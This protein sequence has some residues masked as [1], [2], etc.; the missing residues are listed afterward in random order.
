MDKV[1]PERTNEYGI[2]NLKDL[3]FLDGYSMRASDEENLID[4]LLEKGCKPGEI[5]QGLFNYLFGYNTGISIFES[6]NKLY[7]KYGNLLNKIDEHNFPLCNIDVIKEEFEDKEKEAKKFRYCL[8]SW[9]SVYDFGRSDA[10]I[11]NKNNANCIAKIFFNSATPLS[12][13]EAFKYILM[14]LNGYD[15]ETQIQLYKKENPDFVEDDPLS[16]K[17]IIEELPPLCFYGEAE[18]ILKRYYK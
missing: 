6:E 13:P 16:V 17:P 9:E 8:D 7:D 11:L 15:Y 10:A 3:G 2:Y 1:L 4:F 12:Y 18:Y 14:Y 5:F